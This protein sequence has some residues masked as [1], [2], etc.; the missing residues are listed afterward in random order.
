VVFGEVAVS[1]A[2]TEYG[3]I[4]AKFFCMRAKKCAPGCLV[5]EE[6]LKYV[7]DKGE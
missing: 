3:V 7:M 1:Y 4:C 5:N 6:E 2:K